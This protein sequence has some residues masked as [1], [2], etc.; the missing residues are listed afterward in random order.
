MPDL[1]P[2]IDAAWETR[3]DLSPTNASALELPTVA[4]NHAPS[5]G[6]V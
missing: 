2:A 4:V 6:A 3:S 1:Q 5:R